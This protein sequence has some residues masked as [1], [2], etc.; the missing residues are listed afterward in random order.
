M[1]IRG[2]FIASSYRRNRTSPRL[3]HAVSRMFASEQE[4]ALAVMST[5]E[6]YSREIEDAI[7]KARFSRSRGPEGRIAWGVIVNILRGIRRPD[8]VVAN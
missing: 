4:A 7:G 6:R 2:R 1:P 3:P 5:K 8:G